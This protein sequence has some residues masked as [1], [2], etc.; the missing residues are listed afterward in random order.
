MHVCV[1]WVFCYLCIH[2]VAINFCSCTVYRYKLYEFKFYIWPIYICRCFNVTTVKYI[3]LLSMK[4]LYVNW[5]VFISDQAWRPVIKP[6]T[7]MQVRWSDWLPAFRPLPWP[8]SGLALPSP[9]CIR[10][11]KHA[12]TCGSSQMPRY[13]CA[14]IHTYAHIVVDQYI[15]RTYTYIHKNRAYHRY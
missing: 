6:V 1:F 8:E 9:S 5:Y 7:T 13:M 4:A 11:W 14:N 15:T 10:P 12:R 3:H 2:T